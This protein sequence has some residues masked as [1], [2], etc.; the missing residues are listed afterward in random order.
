[1]LR[2]YKNKE[3]NLND[4]KG[5]KYIFTIFIVII[6]IALVLTLIILYKKYKVQ[7]QEVQDGYNR[8]MYDFVANVNNVENEMLKLRISSN[9][10]Y[11]MTTLA[12]IFAKSNN[13]KAN[14]DILPFS[15]NSVS[16]VSKFLNQLSDFSYSLMRDILNGE[17]IDN[18]TENIETMYSKINELSN[19]V[20][21]IYKE[22]NTGSIKW[23]ELETIGDEKIK[24]TNAQEEVSSVN[25]IGKTFTEYE[26]IIYDGAFSNHILTIKPAYLTGD[27]LSNEEVKEILKGKLDIEEINFIEEQDG[28]LPLYIY[29][30]KL[31][32]SD[33][34]KTIYAT[35]QDGKI[36]QMIS[37]KD[38]ESENITLEEAN[39]KA[40]EF[41]NRLGIY[42]CIQTY[43]LKADNMI[44]ISFAGTQDDVVIYSDLIKIK[45]SLDDG[46]IMNFEANGYIYNHKT[47]DI[48][49]SKTVKEAE[50]TLNK[51]L[52]ITSQKLC[53]IPT[54]SK[55]EVLVYEFKGEIDNKNF[56]I[57]VNAN[58]LVQEKI[59]I[60]LDTPGGTLAI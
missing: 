15:S 10:T 53:I 35:K 7:K 20:E 39:K 2:K 24:E 43:Y 26:G 8:A 49:P 21:E 45:V 29:E 58:T 51:N 23:N 37:Q 6:L 32:S 27:E 25:L 46:E 52:N 44:T 36:Y 47:R 22:L 56:L 59:Y 31:K 9:D 30:V 48:V 40:V 55:D 38:V 42:D 50:D 17:S 5:L 34:L 41:L 1:M 60:L 33:T 14:L 16:N 54:D 13:A 3:T 19:V 11:T 57:Y 18:Y 28:K 12:S 4:K